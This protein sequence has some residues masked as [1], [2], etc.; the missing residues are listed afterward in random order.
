MIDQNGQRF[1]V[2]IRRVGA[3]ML[4][5]ALLSTTALATET[6]DPTITASI[7]PQPETAGLP[8]TTDAFRHILDRLVSGEAET[9]YGEA[10]GLD[11]S[12]ERRALQWAAIYY[13]GGAIDQDT[14]TRFMADAPDFATGPVFKTRLEQAVLRADLPAADV[15]RLLGGS[16]P[17]S[18]SGQ[19]LLARS[20]LETG[21]RDRA[22]AMARSLWVDNFLERDEE[23]RV[24]DIFGSL[25]THQDHWD[26]AVH[27][28]MHDR[29]TGAERLEPFLTD[30]E[31]TLVVARAG[32]ARR[33]TDGKAL[34]DAVD[35]SLKTHPVYYFS[36][37]QRAHQAGLWE[38]AV[39]YLEKVTT[40]VPDAAEWWYER[41]D[42][43]HQL[44]SEGQVGLAYRAANSYQ[45]GP[46]GRLV[47]ARFA[48]G[49]IALC[50]LNDPQSAREHFEK[51]VSLSTLP[52]SIARSNY[53]LG[54]SL[55]MLGDGDGARAAF[56]RASDVGTNYYAL[57]ARD[58]L[59]E[60]GARLRELPNWQQREVA[61]NENEVVR[62]IRLF[63]ANGQPTYAEA[64]LKSFYPGLSDPG[65]F[66]LAARL[67]QEL[68]VHDVAIQIAETATRKGIPLDPY[69]FPSE[70]LPAGAR[71]AEVDMAAIYAIARQE[72]RFQVD[73][74]SSVGARGLMQLM[75]ATARETAQ[76]VGVEYS[77]ARLT[78]DPAYNALLGSTYLAAQL[79]RYNGSLV[80]AAA[81]YNAGGG[82]ANRWIRAYG[83][84]RL[85]NV[86][87][88]IW[89]ELIPFDETRN[90][91]QRVMGNYLMYRARLGNDAVP[92]NDLLRQIP[93]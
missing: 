26:R 7:D 34:L 87:P 75:P 62:A 79:R 42:L 78:T 9:A 39:E 6:I 73:A 82:N 41:E 89:V 77:A 12:V 4:A 91:V 18:I 68:H 21:E 57:L 1:L 22:T 2:G 37:A 24:L 69:N 31:K 3:A 88:V 60:G 49:W 61:F 47:E 44:M 56:T 33:A 32:T 8:D 93:G 80:L 45:E 46:D 71:Y 53:W 83:D 20:L 27:L 15:V 11:N 81:A 74:M 92:I 55:V 67:A 17:D 13:N 64:L 16:T 23:S 85:S 76:Q 38:D 19:I 29:I 51:M 14:I 52:D 72:S 58:V 30:A 84:P 28:M 43:I 35:E 36:R 65:D 90:Y 25:L 48:A 70:G 50:F 66:V 86:D 59:G 54:R 63:A 5:A 10:R 40:N